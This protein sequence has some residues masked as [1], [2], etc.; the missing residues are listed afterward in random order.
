MNLGDIIETARAIASGDFSRRIETSGGNNE[1]DQLAGALNEMAIAIGEQADAKTRA[2]SALAD[3]TERY[4][5]LQANIPGMVYVFVLRPDGSYSLPYVTESSQELFGISAA[6]LVRDATLL[7]SIIHPD[8]FGRYESSVQHSAETLE[9]WRQILRFIVNG[10]TRWY[11]CIS[12]PRQWSDGDIAWDGIVLENTD[13]MEALELLRVSQQKLAGIISASPVGISVYDYSGQ[14]VETNNSLAQMIGATEQQVLEQN[15]RELE[16]WQRSGL[17]D[18]AELA[19]STKTPQRHETATTTSFGKRVCL[20]CHLVPYGEDG[21]LYV[22]QDITERKR[23]EEALSR[24]EILYRSLVENSADI[25]YQADTSGRITYMNRVGLAMLETTEDGMVGKEFQPTIHPDD[26]PRVYAAQGDLY[27]TGEPLLNFECRVVKNRG[28]GGVL[29]VIQNVTVIRDDNGDIVG[30]QGS[31][32]DISERKQMEQ[33]LRTFQ[34]TM[35]QASDAVFWMDSEGRLV[36]TNEQASVS[37]GYTREELAQLRPW[38]I[39]P[40]LSQDL[41]DLRWDKFESTGSRTLDARHRRKDG[42]TFPVEI[43]TR[44]IG[45]PG[46][47]LQVAFA[48]DVTERRRTLNALRESEESLRTTLN[49]IGDGVIAVDTRNRVIHMNPVAEKLSGWR[50]YEARGRLLDEVCRIVNQETRE[51]AD[52][53]VHGVLAK[54]QIYGSDSHAILLARDGAEYAVTCTAAPITAEGSAAGVVLVFRD[55][56]EQLKTEAELLEAKKLES[57]GVLAGGIAHDFNN[58]LTGLF[59]NLELAQ[60]KLPPDHESYEHIETAGEALQRATDLTKQLLT[61]AKGGDPIL[62]AVDLRQAVEATVAFNLSGSNVKA[63]QDL[64]DGLW[65]VK[66]DRGQIS[67]VIAN[68]TINAK[69]AMPDGGSVYIEARNLD[70]SE[71][72]NWQL[73][74]EHV[75]LSLRDDGVGISPQLLER[76]FDPY[77]TT[78]QAGS[79]LGLAVVYSI[80]TKHRGHISVDSV[81]GEGSTFTVLLQ[82]ERSA[83]QPSEESASDAT[84]EPDSGRILVMDDEEIVRYTSAIMLESFG[85][86][87]DDADNGEEALEKYVAANEEG[88]PYDVVIMDLTIPGGMGGKEAVLR[89]KAIDSKA[90]VIVSSGYST[91]PVMA[92]YGDYGFSGRIVKPFRIEDLQNEVRRV[93]GM[94]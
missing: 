15:Y 22:A 66:A 67:Q 45:Q 8:D 33:A 59:G 44:R 91:D 71:S 93:R 47:E 20:D 25:I 87:V 6:D 94:G 14:C 92:N 90:K 24:S 11:D 43:S 61:F 46:S 4:R 12:R 60:L 42:S 34:T 3:A 40:E 88:N 36:Y 62:E 53:P 79:G 39:D 83:R 27:R 28:K 1:A 73:S 80:V 50:F 5:R 2:E 35:D 78:K 19:V 17:L 7:T 77:Y 63:H 75:M 89:L 30:T 23:A 37:L 65:Q 76:I 54:G 21:L 31:A 84:R 56:T 26:L 74:G 9:P 29:D 81:P 57:V 82:A 32:R 18:A 55:V 16:S 68:L 13:R 64:P 49:S 48:R 51:P 69:Q 41:W 86:T 38:N 52:N 58:I 72:A 85:Y 10:E 70:T